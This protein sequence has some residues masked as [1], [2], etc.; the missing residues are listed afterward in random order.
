MKILFDENRAMTL[1]VRTVGI[2]LGILLATLLFRNSA[3][4][5]LSGGLGAGIGYVC[6]GVAERL[7][8][9]K[10]PAASFV[11]IAKTL[12]LVLGILLLC[13]V[14]VCL[15]VLVTVGK[16]ASVIGASIIGIAIG[17][18][19]GVWLILFWNKIRGHRQNGLRGIRS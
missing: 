2:V 14:G 17:G 19:F 15:F 16:G 12:Y 9:S 13:S 4:F 6:G 1:V 3:Y 8:R 18:F 10:V 11:G 5:I 7:L